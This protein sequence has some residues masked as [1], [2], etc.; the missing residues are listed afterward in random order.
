MGHAQQVSE[1]PPT[2]PI[3]RVETGPQHGAIINRIDTDAENRFAV[4]VFWDK[5][6]RVWS[7]PDG[8]LKQAARL[9][10]DLAKIGKAHAVA[11]TPDGMTVA[12]GCCSGSRSHNNIFCS[13]GYRASWPRAFRTCLAGCFTWP[14][15]TMAS[16]SLH[17]LKGLMAS[18]CSM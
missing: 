9:P 16:A 12:V 5:T 6:V 8:W 3:L 14:I 7:L 10:A 4:T 11:I 13:T 2:E 17:L 18:A 1:D 15:P